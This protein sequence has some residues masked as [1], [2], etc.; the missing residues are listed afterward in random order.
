MYVQRV[1]DSVRARRMKLRECQPVADA[2]PGCSVQ[3]HQRWATS[4]GSARAASTTG[5]SR[6]RHRVGQASSPTPSSGYLPFQERWPP[7]IALCPPAPG[8]PPATCRL[9]TTDWPIITMRGHAD[10]HVTRCAPSDGPHGPGTPNRRHR[11]THVTT[12]LADA[13]IWPATTSLLRSSRTKF[14]SHR[15]PPSPRNRGEL[16]E[17]DPAPPGS[18]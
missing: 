10:E 4:S 2:G 9:P 12:Q 1:I 8:Q 3:G 17:A 14:V 11:V 6:G 13:D 16:G 7:P 15:D 5:T 18:Q